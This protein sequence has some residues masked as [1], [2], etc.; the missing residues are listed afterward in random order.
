MAPEATN[1]GDVLVNCQHVSKRVKMPSGLDKLRHKLQHGLAETHPVSISTF[2]RVFW[3]TP[4]NCRQWLSGLAAVSWACG[5]G[6]CELPAGTIICHRQP[7]KLLTL[8]DD[9]THYEVVNGSTLLL[10]LLIWRLSYTPC[11][12][13][14]LSS[15]IK[16]GSGAKPWLIC[17]RERSD[18]HTNHKSI[19]VGSVI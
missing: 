13:S 8:G 2:Y 3:A 19:T 4:V 17:M 5:P 12:P 15:C 18:L 7:Q 14:V 1:Y 11:L 9:T 6:D 16:T 10:K